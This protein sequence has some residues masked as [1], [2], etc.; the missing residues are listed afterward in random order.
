MYGRSLK[1]LCVR[2]DFYI[3]TSTLLLS[4]VCTLRTS[5]PLHYVERIYRTVPML[6]PPRV[7]PDSVSDFSIFP[8]L[9]PYAHVQVTD[10]STLMS[11][12]SFFLSHFIYEMY[13]DI[14]VLLILR[15]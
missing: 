2:R 5:P 15:M 6:F 1:S 4:Y 3:E 12:F 11:T 9:V 13:A 8:R 10:V 7:F 14:S